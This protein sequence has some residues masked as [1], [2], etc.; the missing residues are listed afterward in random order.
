MSD[1]VFGIFKPLVIFLCVFLLD[2]RCLITSLES[3]NLWLF[4]MCISLRFTVS[5]Y[6]FGIFNLWLFLY[7]SSILQTFGYLCICLSLRFTASD[8]LFGIFKPLVIFV[9]VFLLDLRCLI[10]S[11]E[12]STFGYLCICL[13]LRFT[14]NYLFG[15]LCICLSLRFTVSDYLFGIFK[16]LVIF[17]CVFLLDLRCLITSL[18][19]STFGYLCICLSLRFTVSDYRF[20]IFKS[21]VIF[22]F[23]FPLD[24][25]RL[26][27][28][29][30]SSNLWLF[31]Y[32]SFP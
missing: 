1:Y 11:L 22:V 7:L 4:C 25:Q 27:T 5:D 29:L 20:G 15:Y 16:P 18:E 2:L 9:C 17:V 23:V 24:L 26:I 6:L 31:M 28:S 13:S 3:S 10:T 21:L 14:V 8:Y 32:L 30:E 19:S 12:S